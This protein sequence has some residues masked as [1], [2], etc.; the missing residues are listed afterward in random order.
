MVVF[1][2]LFILAI[3]IS[4][5][6]V[7]VNMILLIYLKRNDNQ[8]LPNKL[9]ISLHLADILTLVTNITYIICYSIIRFTWPISKY[10]ALLVAI[11]LIFN[12]IAIVSGCL[13]FSITGLRT[14]AIFRLFY[15]IPPRRFACGLIF[16]ITVFLLSI[17]ISI[18]ALLFLMFPLP[19]FLWRHKFCGTVIVLLSCLNILMSVVA[20]IILKKKSKNNGNVDHERRNHAVVTIVII[21]ILYLPKTKNFDCGGKGDLTSPFFSK[22]AK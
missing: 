21:S 4:L 6:G 3:I 11:Y 15:R 16:M 19:R 14:V 2:Y 20:V 12:S 18:Y 9:M 22:V 8:G 5:F 17:L 7:A 1:I 13:T 10:R